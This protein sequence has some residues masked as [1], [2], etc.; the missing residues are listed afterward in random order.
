[1]K[2]TTNNLDFI[3]DD[4][5]KFILNKMSDAFIALDNDGNY[6][7]LNSKAS[8]VFEKKLENYIGKNIKEGYTE[9][10]DTSFIKSVKLA[11]SEQKH[12]HLE[13]FYKPL[14]KWIDYNVY[15]SPFGVNIF[16]KDI[17]QEKISENIIINE[18]A[19]LEML[20]LN[21]PFREIL[22]TICLG[23][24]KISQNG[25]CSILL[26]SEDG[27]SLHHGA[28]PS[29]PKE[30]SQAI[31][32]VVIG[33]TVGSCG[34][35]AFTKRKVI[36]SDIASDVLCADFKD[37]ALGF[38][39]RACWSMPI[40][41]SNNKVLGTFAVYYSEVK[42]PT[43]NEI[44]F[45][46]RCT[47]LTKIVLEKLR[48]EELIIKSKNQ[49]KGLIEN[50]SGVYWINNLDTKTTLYIS[51]SYE[52][53]WGKKCE[54]LYNNP[55]DFISSIHP[56]DLNT[57]IKSY[58]HIHETPFLN[59]SYRILKPSGETRW[60]KAK[61]FVEKDLDAVTKEYGFAEDITELNE[62]EIKLVN[63]LEK[64][65]SILNTMLDGY[66]L[67]DTQG[68]IIEVNEV[69]CNMMGYKRNEILNNNISEFVYDLTKEELEQRRNLVLKNGRAKFQATHTKKDKSI[70][71]FKV[72]F[73]VLTNNEEKFIAS[74]LEDITEEVKA[75]NELLLYQKEILNLNNELEQKVK[76][77][78][79][80]LEKTIQD[81]EDL[82]DLFVDNEIKIFELKKEIK[83]LK[84][85][86]NP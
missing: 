35:A 26:L 80:E 39:L 21:K 68:K 34:T 23:Y 76:T 2:N 22:N 19:V 62:A 57:V 52:K 69:Y 59:I 3:N 70:I 6:L 65:K 54:D 51:P 1:M 31:D 14:N 5:C 86:L 33:P 8:E 56:D 24:E 84:N 18:R 13:H 64:N 46:E 12:I 53:V 15:P 29:L 60:I 48:N 66:I 85:K 36:V 73:T 32:G 81:L 77:R 10:D 44:H 17:T 20:A 41:D 43:N 71:F 9:D 75:K 74:F 45:I 30:Y 83:E 78:T 82:N 72:N 55:A 49:F 63:E 79:Q 47:Y 40:L 37:L 16:F 7:F 28:A 38:N 27:K 67:T 50:I 42:E 58:S 61:V 25:L 11:Q 4:Y